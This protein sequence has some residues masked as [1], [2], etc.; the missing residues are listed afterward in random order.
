[1]IL[2]SADDSG[3]VPAFD[4]NIII[5]LS[6]VSGQIRGQKLFFVTGETDAAWRFGMRRDQNDLCH[7]G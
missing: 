6:G 2:R 4:F 5:I 3:A 7:R 1:M